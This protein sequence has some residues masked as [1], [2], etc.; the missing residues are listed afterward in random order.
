MLNRVAVASLLLLAGCSGTPGAASGTANG[1]ASGTS[2]G[3]LVI[4]AGAD[5]DVSTT[6]PSAVIGLP[7]GSIGFS[8]VQTGAEWSIMVLSK[9]IAAGKTFGVDAANPAAAEAG[10]AGVMYFNGGNKQWVAESGTI[11]FDK[12]GSITAGGTVLRFNNVGFKPGPSSA[13][14]GTFTLNGTLTTVQPK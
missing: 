11:T 13:G 9:E 2:G 14:K 3:S 5:S 4:T 7:N 1:T 8:F 10:K 12:I 6:L